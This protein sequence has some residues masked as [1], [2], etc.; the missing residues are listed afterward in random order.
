MNTNDHISHLSTISKKNLCRLS[1]CEYDVKLNKNDIISRII[2]E[3]YYDQP[4]LSNIINIKPI[5]RELIGGVHDWEFNM[6]EIDTNNRKIQQSFPWMNSGTLS[7]LQTMLNSRYNPINNALENLFTIN[8]KPKSINKINVDFMNDFYKYF[9]IGNYNTNGICKLMDHFTK[10]S[11]SKNSKITSGLIKKRTIGK[12]AAGIA[13]LVESVHGKYKIIIKKMAS[14]KQY[15]MKSL[16]MNVIMCKSNNKLNRNIRHKYFE[17]SAVDLY[18]SIEEKYPGYSKFNAFIS[19][20]NDGL[21]YLSSAND[22]FTNQTI[23][24]I[25][26]NKILTVYDNDNYIYQYDAYFCE[27]RSSVKVTTSSVI[28]AVTLGH[29]PKT[30]VKRVDAYN[31]MELA[32]AGSLYELLENDFTNRFHDIQNDYENILFIFNDIFVQ[33]FKTLQILQQ[34]KY[35]FVHGDLK[36]KNIFVKTDG[37]IKLFGKNSVEFPRYIY[38]IA[39]YDKSSITWNGIRFYNSGNAGVDILNKFYNDLNRIDLSNALNP[40]YYNLT[41]ICPLIESC[42]SVIG[43]IELETIPIRYLPIPFYCSIDIYSFI[44]SM[45]SHKIF[46]DFILYSITKPIE[47]EP[48]EIVKYLFTGPD[49]PIIMEY[50][51][52]FHANET[53]TK[54]D[55]TSYGQILKVIKMRH[56]NIRKDI[57]YVYD[58]Y[59]LKIL[60]KEQRFIIPELTISDHYNVCLTP[61]DKTCNIVHNVRYNAEKDTCNSR[62]NETHNN[63]ELH[64]SN[65]ETSMNL[66]DSFYLDEQQEIIDDIIQQIRSNYFEKYQKK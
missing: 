28:S 56:I 29:S 44:I 16:D 60:I 26:L 4:K 20:K 27:N 11:S 8:T 1:K 25:I 6:Q 18:R 52:K 47:N 22:N 12:G 39:D 64:I 2:L 57:Q 48:T 58:I 63:N 37:T 38:K 32:D 14:V 61:C 65:T 62:T 24:H 23:L 30:N 51:R 21:I 19:G 50:F 15:R 54:I 10:E 5:S 36:T 66:E 13:F 49:L 35:A 17:Y 33:V 45:L 43:N 46:Y 3:Y 34:S 53:P 31:I 41:K 7:E 59:G 55:M 9:Y 40:D 42:S